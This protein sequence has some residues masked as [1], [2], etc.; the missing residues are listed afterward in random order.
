MSSTM[1]LFVNDN[2]ISTAVKVKSGSI[3]QV[4]PVKITF[5]DVNKWRE[6]WE[7]ELKPKITIKMDE[8]AP[9]PAPAPAPAP[10]V[11][12]PKKANLSDWNVKK[13]ENFKFNLPAGK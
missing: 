2:R 7:N 6:H 11:A 3:L 1:R 12:K 10:V 13:G 8:P 4:Y 5:S 9:T